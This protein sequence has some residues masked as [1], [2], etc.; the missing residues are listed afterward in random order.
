VR[1]A[2]TAALARSTV[3]RVRVTDRRAARRTIERSF[4]RAHGR[5]SAAATAAVDESRPIS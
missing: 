3:A 4:E 5:R 1:V 2:P